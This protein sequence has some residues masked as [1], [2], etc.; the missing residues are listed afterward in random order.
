ML[1]ACVATVQEVAEYTATSSL[2]QLASD[3]FMIGVEMARLDTCKVF[4]PNPFCPSGAQARVQETHC[5]TARRTPAR[6]CA[7]R[8]LCIKAVVFKC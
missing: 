2:P 4:L 7:N 5:H 3:T 8:R 6:L 1:S